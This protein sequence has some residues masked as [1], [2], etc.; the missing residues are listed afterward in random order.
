MRFQKSYTGDDWQRVDGVVGGGVGDLQHHLPGR[1]RLLLLCPAHHQEEPCH[2]AD[3]AA[4]VHD[5][6][7]DLG[8]VFGLPPGSLLWHHSSLAGTLLLHL[9]LQVFFNVF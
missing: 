9:L 5:G 6:L 8:S 7:G 1:P 2:Q 4:C 3:P